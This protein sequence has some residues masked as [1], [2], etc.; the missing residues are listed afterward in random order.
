MRKN[1]FS[2]LCAYRYSNP[3]AWDTLMTTA[4]ST[5]GKGFGFIIPFFIAAWFGVSSSTDA[6][7]F[8]YGIIFFCSVLFAPILESVIVTY[9]AEMRK[10][11]E[12]SSEFVNSILGIG[13]IWAVII[14]TVAI[15]V[16]RPILGFVT[17]FSS[18]ELSLINALLIESSP[19]VVLLVWT[20]VLTGVLNSFKV[21]FLPAVAP[22]FRAIITIAV[23][24]L[25]KKQVGIHAI[26]WGYVIGEFLRLVILFAALNK[27]RI[28]RIHLS[29]CTD[30]RLKAF[31]RTAIYQIIGMVIIS[32]NPLI[33][34]IMAS[35]IQMGGVSVLEYADRLY[36]I[37]VTIITSGLLVTTLAHWSMR[38][39]EDGSKRL[40]HDTWKAMKLV[41]VITAALTFFLLLLSPI[42]VKIA[43]GR[44]A[45]S[46]QML[47]E[48]HT[49][50]FC[51][52]IGFV[53]YVLTQVI[54]RAY[55]VMKNTKVLMY[56]SLYTVILNISLN[57]V[58]TRYFKIAG[59]A[60]SA[61]LIAIFTLVYLWVPLVAVKNRT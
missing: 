5:L 54:V 4:W 8:A 52:M 41:G 13:G 24:F 7:F 29:F 61:S 17:H 23:I 26:A 60:L 30:N 14:S 57:L 43:Y 6:F 21:F 35:W 32:A 27:L 56:C 36:T 12:N 3:L 34:R 45:F 46:D 31:L 48:V 49:V 22:A 11:N 53:P 28:Y 33:N 25:F 51:L 9:I 20:S 1:I 58:L 37:P 38:Y 42:V 15:I 50:F 2:K 47:S 16:A 44:G 18:Q 10:N 55:I 19:L 39:H 59:I 40:M